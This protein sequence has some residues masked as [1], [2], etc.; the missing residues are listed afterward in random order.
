MPELWAI[1]RE[2]IEPEPIEEHQDLAGRGRPR[3]RRAHAADAIA[4]KWM[5]DRRAFDDA[6]GSEVVQ[7][8]RAGARGAACLRDDPFGQRAGVEGTCALRG[9][10]FERLGE[11]LLLQERSRRQWLAAGQKDCRGIRSGQALGVSIQQ[12]C[13]PRAHLEPV[14]RQP[15]RGLEQIGPE[16]L[17]V[18]GM[19]RLHQAH[20]TRHSDGTPRCH[21]RAK[22]KRLAVLH[23]HVGRGA[24]R[25]GLARVPGGEPLRAVHQR[26]G[27]A[28]DAA[29]LGL[30]HVQDRKRRT[31]GIRRRPAGRHDSVPCLRCQGIAATIMCSCAVTGGFAA[32]PVAASGS[33]RVWA[34]AG[35]ASNSTASRGIKRMAG[36]VG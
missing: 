27:A 7:A 25:R 22:G 12:P 3:G 35:A 2:L 36:L 23:E 19:E 6:V 5:A 31:R 8:E 14:A 11:L 34:T 17:A 20:E 30:D 13:Q 28:A 24:G 29:R 9:N 33:A 18:S 10:D 26:E 21:R 32:K 16:E 15:N 4:P 1:E